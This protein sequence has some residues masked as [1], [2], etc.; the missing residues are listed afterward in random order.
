MA[1]NDSGQERSEEA[2]GKRKQEA[3]E[4]GQIPRSKEL[5]TVIMLLVGIAGFFFLGGDMI[6]SLERV[7]RSSFS[8]QRADVFD[9]SAMLRHFG[10]S[11]VAGLQTVMPLLILLVIAAILAPMALG[12]WAFSTQALKPD[13]KKMDPIKGL[14]R[15]FSLKGLMELVKAVA[16]LALVGGAGYLVL[17]AKID[18]FIGLGYEDVQQGIGHIG[19]E[20]LGIIF[21]LSSTLLIVAALDVPFQIWDYARK[22]RMTKQEV[23]DEYKET[24]GSP[25]LKSKIRQTQQ[26]IAQ[27]R[28]MEE[29]P[30]ADVVI[31]NPTHY[32]VA[33]KYDQE[34]GAA[35]I[36]VALGA[37]EVAGHIRRIADANDVPIVSAPPLARA[38]FHNADLGQEIPAGLYLAVAQVLAY[39]YQ[40]RHYEMHGGVAPAFDA[41]VPIPEDLR[42]DA[43]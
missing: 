22:Q 20:L 4:K 14:G 11:V 12:G 19:D 41:D 30:K 1:E 31:T 39:V 27:R 21:V 26:Q 42:R 40:L 36:V 24:E 10:E 3:R 43:G 2:S 33:L 29:V 35:P 16:K 7:M 38:I 28:M 6:T 17:M 9:T 37:D 23:R 18:A 34:R 25:E 13:L 8:L 15:V 5:T 32:A